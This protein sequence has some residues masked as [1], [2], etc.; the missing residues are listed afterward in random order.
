MGIGIIIG[1]PSRTTSDC[2]IMAAEKYNVGP[3]QGLVF[4]VEEAYNTSRVTQFRQLLS[5]LFKKSRRISSF[6]FY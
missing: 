3:K 6:N 5:K 1:Y 2:L 4:S